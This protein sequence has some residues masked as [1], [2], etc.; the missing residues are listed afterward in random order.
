MAKKNLWLGIL[1]M[2]LVFGMT[3][4]GCDNDP[5]DGDSSIIGTW[6]GFGGLEYKFNNN[7]SYESSQGGSVGTGTYSISGN[8]LTLNF[9]GESLTGTYSV[10]GNTLTMTFSGETRTFTRKN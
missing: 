6:V 8:N 7:G 10:N 4:V 1:V 9:E 2:A 5:T 3:I